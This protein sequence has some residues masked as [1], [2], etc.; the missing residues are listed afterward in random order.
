MGAALNKSYDA[1][2]NADEMC[3]ELQKMLKQYDIQVEEEKLS[4][5]RR[6][7]DKISSLIISSDMPV[8][9]IELEKGKLRHL[10]ISY[11]P[12]KEYLYEMIYES[13]YKRLWE[14]FRK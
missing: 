4:E 10:I 6:H 12:D 8:I 2:D 9:D 7:A 1:S 13:R 5:I 3:N 14:Q 11:F